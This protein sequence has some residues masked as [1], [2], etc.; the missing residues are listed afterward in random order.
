[1]SFLNEAM[2]IKQAIVEDRRYLH[3]NAE[4]SLELPKTS[5]YV[6]KRLKEMGYEPEILGDYGVKAVA[7]GK[8]PGKVFLIRGDMDALPILEE[9]DL[10]FK[11]ETGAMHACG[12]DFH[13]SMLLGAAQLLKNHEAEIEGK[14]TLMFQPAEETLLGAQMMIDNG[15]LKNP[16]VDAA[17]MIHMQAAGEAPSAGTVIVNNVDAGAAAADWFV[18]RVQGKGCHGAYP[19]MGV[20]PL[21]VLAHLHLALQAINAREVGPATAL[22]LT[23]GQMHGG[24]TA[25]VIP[26]T[27]MMTG[28]IRTLDNKVRDF[29]KERVKAICETIGAAFRAEVTVTFEAG[30]PV[31]MPDYDVNRELRDYTLEMMGPDCVL[32]KSEIPV[33]SRGM[34]SEDF[35]CV[36]AEVPSAAFNLSGGSVAEGHTFPLHHPK[37]K[38]NEDALPVGAAV[39]ANGAFQWL[40]NHK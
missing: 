28:T 3:Q 29:A 34:G 10:P 30:C 13:T 37:V 20:D 6:V 33:K 22:S 39:Y 4:L 31:V 26:D 18:I 38:F 35:A 24:L 12:H 1:M 5:A 14:V 11:S 2:A 25:N 36:A 19:D 40:K 16:D 21:N 8:K 32:D 27:A 23:V 9:S 7:G 15:I 17:M